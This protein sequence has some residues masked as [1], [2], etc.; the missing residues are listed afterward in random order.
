MRRRGKEKEERKKLKKQSYNLK[1]FCNLGKEKGRE[2]WRRIKTQKTVNLDPEPSLNV[3]PACVCR[4][5]K[6]SRLQSHIDRMHIEC[7]D[8]WIFHA[9]VGSS[10]NRGIYRFLCE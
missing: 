1:R 7:L 5:A 8:V 10:L 9:V 6:I 4:D 3:W 2:W